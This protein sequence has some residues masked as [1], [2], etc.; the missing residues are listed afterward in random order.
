MTVHP[1]HLLCKFEPAARHFLESWMDCLLARR[2][3][4]PRGFL[5]V[6]IRTP[7]PAVP[8]SGKSDIEA[9]IAE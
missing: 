5:S 1:F 6:H 4:W 7:S 9:D 2:S 8:L 3:A